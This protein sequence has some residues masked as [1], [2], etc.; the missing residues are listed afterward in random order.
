MALL[1]NLRYRNYSDILSQ[2]LGPVR[3]ITSQFMAEY[4][5]REDQ[6]ISQTHRMATHA[7]PWSFL[8]NNAES[9]VMINR[10][11]TVY[12]LLKRETWQGDPLSAYL[13][14]H[15]LKVMLIRRSVNAMVS[16]S[17]PGQFL[18]NM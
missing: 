4:D 5:N 3:L 17:F 7:A 12:F 6:Q 13:Y 9:C 1:L 14:I 2:A 15:A 16:D 18:F 8:F 10:H 11:S